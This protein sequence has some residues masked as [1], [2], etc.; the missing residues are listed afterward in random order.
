MKILGMKLNAIKMHVVAENDC[1]VHSTECVISVIEKETEEGRT[2]NNFTI[3]CNGIIL[4][5]LAHK[6]RVQLKVQIA[7]CQRLLVQQTIYLRM[8]VN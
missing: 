8:R 2:S 1:N 6:H 7:V 3:A 4:S 5:L